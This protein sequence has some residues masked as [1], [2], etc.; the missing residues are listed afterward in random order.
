MRHAALL[1]LAAACAP[2]PEAPPPRSR[3]ENGLWAR[4]VWLHEAQDD[5]AIEALV[6]THRLP[7]KRKPGVAR[8]ISSDRGPT[9]EK[10]WM[11]LSF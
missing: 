5:A 3:D 9:H 6:S 10:H 7:L 1:L 2:A 8:S 11:I 4:R